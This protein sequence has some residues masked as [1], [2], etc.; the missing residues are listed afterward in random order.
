M[1]IRKHY[2]RKF[3]MLHISWSCKSCPVKYSEEMFTEEGH[4]FVIDYDTKGRIVGMEIFD[5]E[6]GSKSVIKK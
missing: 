1:N 3:D 4:S 6:K 5:Y 2:T